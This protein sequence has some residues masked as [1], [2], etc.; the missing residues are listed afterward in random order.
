MMEND[1]RFK[2]KFDQVD[3]GYA[4]IDSTTGILIKV[5][6]KFCD[7][8]GLEKD[9]AEG[10]S[11][12]DMPHPGD[13]QESL[14][15]MQELMQGGLDEFTME[16]QYTLEDSSTVFRNLTIASLWTVDDELMY[17][18]A[19]LEDTTEHKSS[20]NQLKKINDMLAQRVQNLT[21]ELDTKT[22]ELEATRKLLKEEVANLREK[23]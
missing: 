7:I 15:K 12:M 6:N 13:V 17:H 10:S 22:S 20:E 18:L 23:N 19:I 1:A 3:I 4:L 8:V 11:F 5:N 9:S 2:A 21:T 16:L 14:H